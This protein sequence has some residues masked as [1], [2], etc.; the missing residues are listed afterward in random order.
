MKFLQIQT[1]QKLSKRWSYQQMSQSCGDFVGVINQL[2]KFSSHLAH[3]NQLLQ[4]LLKGNNMRLWTDQ[5]EDTMQKLKAEIC[6]QWLLAHYISAKSKI[7]A[8]ASTYSLG[9][10]LLQS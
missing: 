6:S 3:L 10:V 1:K 4:E 5:H 7:T 9:A 2:N 8:D